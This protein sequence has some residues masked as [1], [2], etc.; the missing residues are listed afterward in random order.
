M[1]SHAGLFVVPSPFLTRPDVTAYDTKNLGQ[2]LEIM[3]S[4]VGKSYRL[5]MSPTKVGLT[6]L[7]AF[8]WGMAQLEMPRF[9]IQSLRSE[10]EVTLGKPALVGTVSPPKQIQIARAKRVWLAFV[11]L[12]GREKE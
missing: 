7:D 10:F 5:R 9:S 4:R 6:A 2:T 12:G 1:G 11:T 3:V 8:G